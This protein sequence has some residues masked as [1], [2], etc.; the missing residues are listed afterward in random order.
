[1]TD[2]F[3]GVLPS[4]LGCN[5]FYVLDAHVGCMGRGG[6]T[7]YGLE[8]VCLMADEHYVFKATG[9]GDV[10]SDS[11]GEGEERTLSGA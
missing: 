8:M 6:Q 10:I 2:S 11:L 5:A 4:T 3:W 9:G 7:G 1:M